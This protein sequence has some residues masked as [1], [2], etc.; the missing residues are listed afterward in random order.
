MIE[1]DNSMI[2]LVLLV[3][4][5]D[6]VDEMVDLMWMWIWEIFSVHFLDDECEGNDD[7]LEEKSLEFRDEKILNII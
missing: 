3:E 2:L 7:E 1:K 4:L 5:E 6:L